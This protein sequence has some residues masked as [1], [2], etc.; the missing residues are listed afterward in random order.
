M[1]AAEGGIAVICD[2]C[3]DREGCTIR[4]LIG[5]H[6]KECKSYFPDWTADRTPQKPETPEDRKRPMQT[7]GA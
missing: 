5:R 3:I 2:D 6:A 7:R 1:A 4:K